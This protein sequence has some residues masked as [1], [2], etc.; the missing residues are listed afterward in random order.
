MAQEEF[1]VW[2][3]VI[4]GR[5]EIKGKYLVYSS[6]GICTAWFDPEWS[7]KFQD[8]DSNND[9]GMEDFDGNVFSVSHWRLLPEPPTE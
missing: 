9:E 4:D 3:K 7:N 8:C 2:R 1:I 5:P 6:Y